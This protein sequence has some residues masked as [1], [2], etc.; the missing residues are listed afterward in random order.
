M[1]NLPTF[2]PSDFVA[3]LNQ[4]FEYAYPQVVVEG[5]IANFKVSK[6][7][8]VYFDL[9]DDE[10]SVKF[11]GSVYSLPGPLED[12]LVV[13]VTGSPRLS[14]LYGF[15]VN[16]RA[17]Q[18]VGEGSLK[19]AADLL[20]AKLDRE[21]LF[22][23]ARKRTIPY[24]AQRIGLVTSGESAAYKDFV[25]VLGAR[26]QDAEITHVDVGVQGEQ[27]VAEVVQAIDSLNQLSSLD[28]IVVIRGGGSAD[29][30]AVFS[31]EQVTR[32]VAASRT[33]TM[34]AIGHER[35]VSLA[36]LAA[37]VRGSTPS[38]AAEL[39]APESTV[40]MQSLIDLRQL[41]DTRLSGVLQR[42]L[43]WVANQRGYALEQLRNVYVR[44]ER[45]LDAWRQQV[46]IL[47]P[48][49]ALRRGYAV[50]RQ[51]GKTIRSVGQT[52]PG[53]LLSIQLADGSIETKV[54]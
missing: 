39:L 42:E 10:A 43:D 1:D 41:A 3:S 4:T 12:G 46:E 18:A 30:L 13:R 53:D 33:P 6:D 49:A 32:A 48:E 26:W 50:V 17:I 8:W 40:V 25:K 19:R 22:D 7:K 45:Q 28:V 24:P 34:V 38:N 54:Q 29:D 27:A 20:R 31:T 11:F 52:K 9:K 35:D 47:N 36:E 23:P 15:S 37:D 5:E 44:A 51:A 14:Q 21:G 16:F 2:T